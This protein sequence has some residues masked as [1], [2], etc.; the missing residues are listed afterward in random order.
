[1]RRSR[2]ERIHRELDAAHAVH[3]ELDGGDPAVQRRPIVLKTRWDL[4]GL[5]LNVHRDLQQIVG[6][7]RL[8]CPA[9]EGAARG[10]RQGRRSGDA[11]ALG[12]LGPS[13]QRGILQAIMAGQKCQKHRVVGS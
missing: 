3:A 1:M 2:L 6:V 12:R 8:A 7:H 11:G 5:A 13:G 4:D 9:G 10:D